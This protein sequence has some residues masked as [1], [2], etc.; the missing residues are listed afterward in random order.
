MAFDSFSIDVFWSGPKF[1]SFSTEHSKQHFNIPGLEVFAFQKLPFS[2]DMYLFVV[3]SNVLVKYSLQ[4]VKGAIY[5]YS[6]TPITK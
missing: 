6:I 5:A 3:E 4:E 1:I 2:K